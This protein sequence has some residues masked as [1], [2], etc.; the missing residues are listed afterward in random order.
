MLEKKV[1]EI[2]NALYKKHATVYADSSATPRACILYFHG[3]GLLYGE[4]DDLPKLHIDTLTGA[5]YIIIS[6]DYPL[7]PAAKLNTILD[8]VSSSISHYVEYSD[9]YCGCELP[10]FLWGRSAGAYLCLLAAAQGDLPTAP[11]GILSYYG[12]G[13]LCDGWFETPSS[14]YCSLPPVEA[15]CLDSAGTELRSSGSLDT[16]YSIYVYARQ[17]GRW[18]SL[19]YE[20]REKYFYLDYTLRTCASLPCPL[21]CAHSTNDPDVPYEEFLALTGRYAAKQFIAAGSTHDFDRVEEDPFTG[22]LLE[23]TLKFL[24][25]ARRM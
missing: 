8:D 18:R 6:Y 11:K 10:F 7:A 5:G 21:F 14:F 19:L 12:Y 13:F 23:E 15:S 4:R 24:D 3:G 2:S 9:M 25:E 17:T 16:H 22:S 1:I 20:G